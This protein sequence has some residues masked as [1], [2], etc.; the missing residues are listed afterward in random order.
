MLFC[1]DM[2][3]LAMETYGQDREESEFQGIM[4]SPSTNK[5]LGSCRFSKCAA[6]CHPIEPNKPFVLSAKVSVFLLLILS[7]P[8][9]A[10]QFTS[11]P[12]QP[13]ILASSCYSAQIGGPLGLGELMLGEERGFLHFQG[14]LAC[15]EKTQEMSAQR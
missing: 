6:Q 11:L 15:G 8:S 13:A 3:I 10:C 4:P 9:T 1:C 14:A 12:F 2:L 7:P 5:Y